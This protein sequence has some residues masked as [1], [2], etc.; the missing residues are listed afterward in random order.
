MDVQTLIGSLSLAGVV[1]G[2]VV[3]N[4]GKRRDP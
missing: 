2:W 4:L 3:F 1:L